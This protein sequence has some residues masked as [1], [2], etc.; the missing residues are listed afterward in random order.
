MIIEVFKEDT[1]FQNPAKENRSVISGNV[2][3]QC[4]PS[5]TIDKASGAEVIDDY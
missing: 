5:L 2:I 4:L 1:G 3:F